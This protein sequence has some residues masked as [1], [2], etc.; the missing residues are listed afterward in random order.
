M[1][2]GC[3]DSSSDEEN[4]DEI[5]WRKPRRISRYDG[6]R[7]TSETNVPSTIRVYFDPTVPPPPIRP[8]HYHDEMSPSTSRGHQQVPLSH[9]HRPVASTDYDARQVPVIENRRQP[10][11]NSHQAPQR[12]LH[13]RQEQ[14]RHYNINNRGYTQNRSNNRDPRTSRNNHTAPELKTAS[15]YKEHRQ[16]KTNKNPE[17]GYHKLPSKRQACSAESSSQIESRRPRFTANESTSSRPTANISSL[18][19][20]SKPSPQN[21]RILN[22][23]KKSVEATVANKQQV[24][25]AMDTTDDRS[26]N[27]EVVRND[28]TLVPDQPV[29][30]PVAS[31][32][33]QSTTANEGLIPIEQIKKEVDLNET[34]HLQSVSEDL[35]IVVKKEVKT[36]LYSDEP[37]SCSDN[38]GETDRSDS[39]DITKRTNGVDE[40]LA[41]TSG[42]H[43]NEAMSAEPNLRD[44]DRSELDELVPSTSSVKIKQ[45]VNAEDELREDVAESKQR[46]IRCIPI[47]K[48]LMIQPSEPDLETD[49]HS[50]SPTYN[51]PSSPLAND[52]DWA[53]PQS[54]NDDDWEMVGTIPTVPPP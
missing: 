52:E 29:E 32:S 31:V 34:S 8:A 49:F 27:S 13:G 15:T 19:G 22:N 23:N 21:E 14:S 43:I 41:T 35:D 1:D 44:V 9:F 40:S 11:H 47:N 39:P 33:A 17:N 37:E 3:I 16:N 12:S 42:G 30:P 51:T 50:Q 54:D 2:G 38:G 26:E 45:E 48:M 53:I 6:R 46:F 4:W 25:E 10:I 20:S 5:R 28:V 24:S 36:E 18:P 7:S